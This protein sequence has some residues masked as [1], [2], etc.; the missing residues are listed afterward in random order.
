MQNELR[1]WLPDTSHPAWEAIEELD[2]ADVTSRAVEKVIRKN[3][4]DESFYDED[5]ALVFYRV[6]PEHYE[7]FEDFLE[8]DW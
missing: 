6:L 4:D 5:G 1:L 3:A 7:L 2:E 8:N